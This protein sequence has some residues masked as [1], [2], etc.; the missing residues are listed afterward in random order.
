MNFNKSYA[1]LKA[2]FIFLLALSF[3]LPGCQEKPVNETKEPEKTVAPKTTRDINQLA[4][5][6]QTKMAWIPG[7]TFQMGSEEP[8][9]PDSKPVHAVTVN[10]FWMDEH[11]V[12]YGQ[13]AQFIKA[14]GYKTVAE[15]PLNPADFPGVAPDKLVPGSAVFSAPAQAVSLDNS[16][17]WWQYVAGANWSQPQGPE[18]G[19]SK[20]KNTPV[21][22]VSYEDA[23]AYARW[24]GKRLPT[25]AEW[26][27]AAR[28]GQE[29]QKYYWGNELKPGNKWV[30]N[31]YQ[32]NFPDKNIGEDGFTGVAP[33]KSFLPNAF[34]LYDMEGN[35]WEW[36]SDFYRPDYYSQSPAKNPQG[37][38]DSYDPQEPNVVK[39]V[40]RGGSFLCSDQ[41]CI[42]YKAGSRGKGEVSSST[43]NLGFRC[44]K[45][46]VK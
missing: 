21:V 1:A 23:L 26:E 32:G 12:T 43:D 46:K 4:D 45:D 27:Y 38:A 15:Q 9:F 40:Q 30:A 20:I 5:T 42:R 35:V 3:L 2:G 11:E 13:Y 24:A 29:K 31:I 17:V 16:L 41:Y 6:T 22:Q 34:G 44:V 28:G 8:E 18:V 36:C 39:R 7:G 37:P 19:V 14:T 33:V 25:E 10:G